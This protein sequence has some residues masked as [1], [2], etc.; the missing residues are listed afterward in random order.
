[1][2][3]TRNPKLFYGYII[4]AAAFVMLT[5]MGGTYYSFGV[6]FTPLLTEFG[7]TRAMTSGAFSLS[8]LLEGVLGIVMGKATDRWGPRMVIT[9]CGFLLGLGYLL[10]PQIS[11]LWHFYLLYGVIIG[12]G[13]GGLWVPPVSIVIRWFAKRRNTMTGIAIAG[14]GVGGLITPPLASSP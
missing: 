13:L 10:M 11:A 1:L 8:I 12:I 3:D 4:V 6:F 5:V 14:T 9:L 2:P 7:W